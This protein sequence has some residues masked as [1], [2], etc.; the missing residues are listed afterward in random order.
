MLVTSYFRKSSS[1]DSPPK[2]YIA[3]AAD[4]SMFIVR[5]D[6]SAGGMCGEGP[7]IAGRPVVSFS[8]LTRE[9]ESHSGAAG[10]AVSSR[11]LTTRGAIPFGWIEL[12][13]K[14]AEA[15]RTHRRP[16]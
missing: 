16:G 3:E 1:A 15:I 11:S 14:A 10:V 12:L 4:P 7:H 5:C 9:N 8:A 2:R 6:T 13:C